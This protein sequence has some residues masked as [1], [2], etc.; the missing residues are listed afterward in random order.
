MSDRYRLTFM[1]IV[2]YDEDL[3]GYIRSV[4]SIPTPNSSHPHIELAFRETN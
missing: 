1:N 2:Q 3:P 4:E